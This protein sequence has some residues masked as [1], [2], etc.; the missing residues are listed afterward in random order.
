LSRWEVPL[1]H[2]LDGR[3]V[4]V[5]AYQEDPPGL[6]LQAL[7]LAQ[8][9]KSAAAEGVLDL[10]VDFSCHESLG[11]SHDDRHVEDRRPYYPNDFSFVL[12]LHRFAPHLLIGQRTFPYV[13]LSS[14][15]HLP[16]F[17]ATSETRS[18]WKA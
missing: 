5:V 9:V 10:A 18:G 11:G 14:L 6:L 16:G 7:Q 15:T 17:N 12:V 4:C 1:C 13:R 8:G 2:G 3:A